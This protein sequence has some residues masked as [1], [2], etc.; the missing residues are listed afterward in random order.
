MSRLSFVPDDGVPYPSSESA[1]GSLVVPHIPDISD[2]PLQFLNAA[3]FS[4][5]A[6]I[7]PSVRNEARPM[8]YFNSE[9]ERRIVK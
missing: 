6:P 5:W 2:D 3:A 7:V 4:G 1:F 9:I 8:T